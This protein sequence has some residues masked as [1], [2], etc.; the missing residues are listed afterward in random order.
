MI[1]LVDYDFCASTKSTKLIPN[2]EIMKLASYYKTEENQFCRLLNIDEQEL[3]GYEKIYFFSELDALPPIP[4]QFLRS[5]NVIYG[6]TAFTNKQYIPFENSIIDY[7]IPRTF[8][9]KEALK[10]KYADGVKAKVISHVLDNTYYRNYAGDSKLPLPA[11]IPNKQV[12][13]YDRDFFYPDWRDTLSLISDRRPSSIVRVHPIICD[14]LSTYFELRSY[15]KFSRMNEI[16]LDLNIPLDEVDYML[17]HYKNQFLADITISSNVY[18]PLGGDLKTNTLYCKDLI[19]KLN[20]LY[21]FWSRGVMIKM[22]YIIPNIGYN[23]PLHNLSK[24]IEMWSDMGF[25]T[26]KEKTLNDKII[27]KTKVSKEMEERDFLLKLFPKSG[28]LFNQSYDG[29]VERRIWR[30]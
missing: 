19:Y 9:Y 1:G 21:A 6:G 28:D 25:K 27:L 2:I 30:L 11:I 22:K 26:R 7:T 24:T 13:L 29:L 17:K 20:L 15:G 23:N 18:L 8:I 3:N 10:Q 5:N 12:I 14:K 16:I 4:E